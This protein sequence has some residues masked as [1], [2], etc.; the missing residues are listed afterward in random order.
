[1]TYSTRSPGRGFCAGEAPL[2]AGRHDCCM[3]SP[4]CAACGSEL[5]TIVITRQEFVDGIVRESVVD[6][7][8]CPSCDRAVHDDDIDWQDEIRST[9]S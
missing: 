8:H 7:Y 5:G 2:D 6:R 9:A 3:Q 1:M 4:Y